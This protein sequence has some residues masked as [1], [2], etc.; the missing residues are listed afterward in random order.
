MKTQIK[1]V[2]L[3]I[4]A[5]TVQ[6]YSQQAVPAAGGTVN[7]TSG[8]FSFT[9]GQAASGYFK[10][11]SNSMTVGVQQTYASYTTQV[12][13]A[14]C[15]TV[16]ANLD[17]AILADTIVGAQKY[18]FEVSNGNAIR[19]IESVTNSF[20]LAQLDGGACFNTVYAIRV[21]VQYGGIWYDYGTSC[22]V[23]TP[24]LAPTA[25][26]QVF[27]AYATVANLVATGSTIQWYASANDGAALATTTAL[28]TGTYYASQTVNGCES[29]RTAVTV[30]VNETQITASAISICSGTPVAITASANSAGATTLPANLQNGLVGYWP[31]NGNA[32]DASGNGNNGIV[33][34]ATLTTDRFGNS[35][36][37]YSFDGTSAY[38]EVNNI[39]NTVTNKTFS[40]W[41]LLNS[42][43]QSGAGLV[44]IVM[45]GGNNF[46]SIVYNEWNNG[47]MFGSD[48]F[49]R[50]S[51]SN[52]SEINKEWVNITC[53]YAPNDY[54]MYRNGVLIHQSTNYN[55]LPFSN[56][57]F[58]FGER[59][60]G[61]IN[62]FL[63]GKID[64]I[65]IYNR[66][67]SLSEIQQLNNSSTYLWST[68]ETT[69]TINPTPTETTTYWCDVTVNGVTCRKEM[70]ITVIPNTAPTA[71]AQTFCTAST[72]ASLTASGNDIQWYASAND[73]AALATT[74]AL[75]TETYY[76][77]QTV[78]G[79]ESTRTAVNITVNETQI[80][81]SANTVCSGVSIVLQ[82][83][84]TI[85]TIQ[86][87]LYLG[88]FQGHYYYQSK[89]KNGWNYFNN[90]IRNNFSNA[91]L[92]VIESAEENQFITANS[93]NIYSW[94]G[95]YQ[96]L[97]SSDYFE[98]NGGWRWVNGSLLN[99]Y[100]NWGIGEPNNGDGQ[101]HFAH[102]N[103]PNYS[104]GSWND[105][106]D[107]YQLNAIFEFNSQPF[108]NATYTW[109]TGETT[110]TINPTPTE[111][112]TY[113]CDVTAN[114]VT[115]RKEMTITVIPNTAPT[116]AAQTF[117][118]A[119]TIANLAATGTDV[120][121]YAS[122]N[123]GAAL[124]TTTALTTGTY[125]ASQTVNGCESTRTAVTVTVNETQI[126]ASANTVCSGTAVTITASATSAGTTNLPSNLQNG[127]V[128]YWPF[129][130]NAND[131]SGN[132]NNGTVNGATLTIDRFGNSNGAYSFDNLSDVISMTNIFPSLNNYSKTISVWLKFPIQYNY[133]SLALVKNGTAYSTG[134][135]LAIDQ[136]NS[137]YGD[138]NYLV[139]FL[140]GNG[141]AITFISNQSELGNWAN[142]VAI[143]N[144]SEIKLYLNGNLKASQPFTGNL[145]CTDSNIYFGLWDNPSAPE[146]VSR[147]LDDVAIYNRELSPQEI[148]QLYTQGQATYS[149]ST[150]E[151]TATIN[152]TPTETTT[153][154][155]DV[156]VNG[157]TCRK[158]MTITVVPQVAP[159]FTQ[160]ASTCSGSN[161]TAL[162]TTSNNGITGTWS[163][164]I[165]NNVTTTYIF[166][167][168]A[169]QC[170][171]TTTQTINITTPKVTS[172]ISFVA[173]TTTVAALPNVTIGTQIWTSKNLDVSTYRDGTPI[174][175]V[176]DP[177]QWENLTTG[178]WCY[179]NNDEANGAIY[180]K[181]YNWY[182]VAGIHDNDP[183]TPNKTL[184]PS[185][186][187][188]GSDFEYNTLVTFLGGNDIAGGKM[189][190]TGTSLWMS[191]NLN[192]TNSSYF[193]GLPGGYR[194]YDE[195]FDY[196]GN[197]GFWW[198][199]SEYDS[200][201]ARGRFINYSG[202][203]IYNYD[204]KKAY[205]MSVRLIKD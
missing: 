82:I 56:S 117:C 105:G 127:L 126:T 61:H 39:G 115:C 85:P 46:D 87:L 130:G 74:T 111:T 157:V 119:S 34:G 15:A 177:S 100:S 112:T 53:S 153:Y 29:T 23:T 128:G 131:V 7:G 197:Y 159:T 32:N 182:A 181:L 9:V 151:T 108:L 171:T 36:S 28:T 107:I 79:C 146:V 94:I 14:Q 10:N 116:A 63:N 49:T 162:P 96:D 160:I 144:G 170:A 42:L 124:A 196:I 24:N 173:P 113:W 48:T 66:A 125:Y 93:N 60:P 91:Y 123:D 50:S 37:A 35:N 6:G 88:E 86:D 97:T 169:G 203:F 62:A 188:V 136:N 81:A 21:A 17:T 183:N 58:L 25:T 31:F 138:N 194:K 75:T 38:I 190:S 57:S 20:T 150:G 191:P 193:T 41:V 67:L 106:M 189:K 121:W 109:S 172:P 99:S 140:A 187:H 64:D 198:S 16:L 139:V 179:Y 26:P 145:N 78:N 155:C 71:A 4:L 103:H 135:D 114:G 165:N 69:A 70:T 161:L 168:D 52:Y 199:S 118:S 11:S 13:A 90:Y 76:A 137:A 3:A 163:P 1:I 47:W 147:Q 92:C 43:S 59:H 164:E 30:T 83:E 80:T 156:M 178:A 143:Y 98:P 102:I 166:N 19:T 129:N 134:F 154:W 51:T 186:W 95:L 2:I 101:E 65:A 167:P 174:P 45:N 180:G 158:E 176:T 185:G 192:A 27:C 89:I 132:G 22:T 5:L 73:G 148:A 104:P 84:N 8:S 205:G 202:G 152:P 68:G 110:A 175:Q 141:G 184:A 33:N 133:S 55:I 18:R 54:R 200:E 122:A 44:S 72:I 120:K 142:L 40:A 201:N 149:W 195:S 204:N 77:S 12:Q